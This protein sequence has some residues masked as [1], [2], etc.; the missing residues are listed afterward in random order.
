[1]TA[2]QGRAGKRSV[3][4]RGIPPGG[5]PRRNCGLHCAPP[6]LQ[7]DRSPAA[8]L[9]RTYQER[10]I[11]SSPQSRATGT[12]PMPET[13]S[14]PP[15]SPFSPLFSESG[16]QVSQS[17]GPDPS[18]PRARGA[19][20]RF[21]KGSSGNPRGRPRGIRNP[22]RRVPDLVRRPL[23]PRALS[24]LLDRKPHLLRPLVLQLLPP[25]LGPIDPAARLGIDLSS[26][27]TVED[28]RRLLPIVLAGIASG[29][30][31]PAE[32]ARLAR[33]VRARLRALRRFARLVRRL[34]HKT[35]PVRSGDRPGV[36]VGRMSCVLR[37]LASRGTSG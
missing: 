12:S 9:T 16:I 23:S 32:G 4:R 1:M 11:P 19:R 22:R 29:K 18:S 24:N 21:A 28:F 6:A 5:Y 34:S 20:G 15:L 3:T 25:P 17:L 27:R 2:Q 30:I 36:G 7:I 14:D 10:I 37:G 33:R 8:T 31:A 35:G 26:P 13:I